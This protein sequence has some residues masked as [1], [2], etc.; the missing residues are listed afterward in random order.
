MISMGNLLKTWFINYILRW[1]TLTIDLLSFGEII[2]LTIVLY[3]SILCKTNQI[4]EIALFKF[5]PNIKN[6]IL[7][8]FYK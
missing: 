6:T 8:I 3:I 7:W 1:F 4:I 5:P 2:T